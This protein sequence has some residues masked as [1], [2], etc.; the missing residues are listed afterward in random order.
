MDFGPKDKKEE[1]RKNQ[2]GKISASEAGGKPRE[3]DTPRSPGERSFKKKGRL[4]MCK[5][6]EEREGI[7]MS[8]CQRVRLRIELADTSN[9]ENEPKNTAAKG[10][11][12]T[13]YRLLLKLNQKNFKDH[14]ISN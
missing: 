1:M 2:N 10:P 11:Q 13:I 12:F 14:G 3:R 5:R 7:T 6:E 8:M 9:L 4:Q